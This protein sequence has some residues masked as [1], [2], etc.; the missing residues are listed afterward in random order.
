MTIDWQGEVERRRTDIIRTTQTFLRIRSVLN[1]AQSKEGM[2]FGPGIQDAMEFLL[3]RCQTAGF[4]VKRLEGYAAHAEYGSGDD[5]LG[6]LCHVDVVPEGDGWTTPPYEASI[7]DNRIYARGAI[8]DKGPTMAA[9]FAL[10]IVK[11][12]ALPLNRRV[13]LIIGGDE[14]SNW[15]SSLP[16]NRFGFISTDV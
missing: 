16:A 11:E 6:I 10:S 5:L 14:E 3:Q 7:R 9:F 13:R 4:R 12:L 2:P 1:E 8:D 15:R